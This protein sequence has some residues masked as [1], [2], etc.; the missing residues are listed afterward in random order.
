M[1]NLKSKIGN[2][3]LGISVLI[4]LSFITYIQGYDRGRRSGVEQGFDK[5]FYMLSDTILWHLENTNR[6]DTVL[7]HIKFDT[8]DFYI[9]KD[10]F[11]D[12]AFDEE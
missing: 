11:F 5:G 1:N 8:I 4:L 2:Y 3:L 7:T 10:R 9:N 6:Y 12:G